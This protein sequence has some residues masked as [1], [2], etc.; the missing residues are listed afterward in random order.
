MPSLENLRLG[1]H[2]ANF[3]VAMQ[4]L[5]HLKHLNRIRNSEKRKKAMK[6]LAQS[7][8][9]ARIAPDG[10]RASGEAQVLSGKLLLAAPNGGRAACH[11]RHHLK[12]N[13]VNNLC[14]YCTGELTLSERAQRRYGNA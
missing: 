11:I 2:S 8:H 3:A 1:P 4:Q 6:A 14:A 12:K 10:G 9:M 7:G 13:K 5:S